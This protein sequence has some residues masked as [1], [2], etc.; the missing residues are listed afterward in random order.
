MSEVRIPAEPRTEFGKGAA[1]RTRR[2]HKVP[3]VLYGHGIA[4]RHISLP[5]HELMLALKTPNV[6]LSLD[7]GDGQS[8]LAL[9]R[10]V[11]RDPIK[12]FIEHVDLITVSRGEKVVVDVPVQVTGEPAAGALTVV[13]HQVLSVE[14]EATHIPESVE[15]SIEGLE[16]G[17]QVH[18]GEVDL[19]EGVTLNEDPEGLLV[20]VTVAP[21]AA[22]VEADLAQTEAELGIVH[23]RAADEAASEAQ[24]EAAGV[25][26]E[27]SD[28]AGGERADAQAQA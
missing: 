10:D 1:R 16:P 19:P 17:T 9:P 18:A 6:L 12:G 13:D 8:E 3:A 22:D 14:A 27:T 25:V 15:V 24:A 7:L 21:T 20:N 26:S 11:Q 5:G 23:E 4:P 28:E 2:A